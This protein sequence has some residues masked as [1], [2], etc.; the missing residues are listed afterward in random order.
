[1]T[2]LPQIQT[3]YRTLHNLLNLSY[4]PA[5]LNAAVDIGLFQALDGNE[6]DIDRLCEKLNTEKGIT[7]ALCNVLMAMDLIR[8]SQGKYRL[9]A[10]AQEFLVESSPVNQLLGI[11]QYSGS[12]GPFDH[13]VNALKGE[14]P[15]FNPKMWANKAAAQRME[16]G[17]KA[18]AIQNVVE[19]VTALPGFQSLHSLCDLAGNIGHYSAAICAENHT[20]TAHVYDL[21]EVVALAPGL[22]KGKIAERIRF[23]ACDLSREIDLGRGYDLFFVSHFLYG[24]G[25][26]NTLIPLLRKINQA[27]A[28]S[29]YFVSH[30][31]SGDGDGPLALPMAMVELM[32]KAMGYPTHTL[33]VDRL[34][35]A[36]AEAGFGE[37]IVKEPDQTL[38]YPTTLLAAKKIKESE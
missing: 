5:I 32:T 18:G 22:R 17:A 30:H 35:G 27:M 38:D 14:I 37:F 15:E 8:I 24:H 2:R 13:L 20:L 7:A 21:S 6:S 26:E 23:H 19:F 25:A 36:L 10:V 4:L 29:G 11:R 28:H 9:A 31:I 34:K 1:M 12:S 33:P 3:E 16:Q